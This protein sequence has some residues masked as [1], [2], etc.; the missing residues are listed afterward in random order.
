MITKSNAAN[1]KDINWEAVDKATEIRR[2]YLVKDSE[3]REFFKMYKP[4]QAREIFKCKGW[5]G[6]VVNSIMTK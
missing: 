6:R 1:P 4:S 2:T 3:G 5:T